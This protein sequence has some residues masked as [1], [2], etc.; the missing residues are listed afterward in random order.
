VLTISSEGV[1]PFLFVAQVGEDKRSYR[2]RSDFLFLLGGVPFIL[3][4]ICSDPIHESDRRR[5]L[6]QAGV[7]VRVVN[8]IEPENEESFIAVAVYITRQ[9]VAHRYLVYQPDKKKKEVCYQYFNRD[10]LQLIT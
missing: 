4:E 7:L 2:P 6:L 5:M 10:P 9:L 8:S 3:F 1:W